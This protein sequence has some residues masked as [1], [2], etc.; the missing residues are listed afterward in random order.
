MADTGF[1]FDSFGVGWLETTC[2]T[3]TDVGGMDFVERGF[4][5]V[6]V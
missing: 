6:L 5:F 1:A 2:L 4:A 3:G